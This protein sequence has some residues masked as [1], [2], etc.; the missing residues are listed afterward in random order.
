MPENI[1]FIRKI[2]YILDNNFSKELITS[3]KNIPFSISKEK[4]ESF[5]IEELFLPTKLIIGILLEL[6]SFIISSNESVSPDSETTI[7][8]VSFVRFL[9]KSWRW[10]LAIER[11]P[12]RVI[13]SFIYEVI[14]LAIP[15][16]KNIIKESGLEVKIFIGRVRLSSISTSVLEF[17]I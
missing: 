10:V 14:L 4:V 16:D 1:D 3:A 7:R 2:Y 5:A 12:I 8:T 13:L 15:T 11:L 17:F 9:F 6:A